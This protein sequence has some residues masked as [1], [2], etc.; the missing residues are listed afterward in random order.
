MTQLLLAAQGGVLSSLSMN[1]AQRQL[2]KPRVRAVLRKWAAGGA[3][4][5]R[6]CADCRATSMLPHSMARL[7]RVRSSLTKCSATWCTAVSVVQAAPDWKT[8][9]LDAVPRAATIH[10]KLGP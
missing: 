3:A 1:L 4:V 6:A 2:S 7:N 5:Q 10:C 9:A 8:A